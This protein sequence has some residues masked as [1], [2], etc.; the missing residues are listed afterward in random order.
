MKSIQVLLLTLAFTSALAQKQNIDETHL[1][2]IAELPE[3]VVIRYTTAQLGVIIVVDKKDSPYEPSLTELNDLLENRKKLKIRNLTDL[4]NTLSDIGFDY[5]NTFS[6]GE[7][8]T[9]VVFRKKPEYR[10]TKQ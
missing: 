10:Q 7:D 3:Y 5:V 8:V 4:L 1:I 2:D 6:I 9:G